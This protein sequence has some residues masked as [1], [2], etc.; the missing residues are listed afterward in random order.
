[1]LSALKRK[2][3]SL[4]KP[5]TN[6]SIQRCVV[7]H[8]HLFKNAGSTLDWALRK[9]FG[10]SFVDHR[11]DEQMKLGAS[12]L[13]SYIEQHQ[14]VQAL[15][16]HHL[17]LP[18]P[19][20]SDTPLLLLTLFRHPIERVTSV[21]KF[22][23]AQTCNSTPGVI[24]ARKLS[25]RDYILWRMKPRVGSTIR[26]FH[27]RRMLPPRELGQ[28]LISSADMSLINQT[29]ETMDMVGTVERF[30]ESM[31]LFE[32]CLKAYYPEIDLSYVPQNVGQDP[33][34]KGEQRL[35]RLRSD[36]GDETYNLLLEKNQADLEV[37]SFVQNEL[38]KRI[39]KT[40]NFQEKLKD[41]QL[42]CQAS[43]G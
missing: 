12:Y 22:E 40:A 2:L 23:R 42:R 10:S 5:I 26:N 1:M 43:K 21:Y 33:G 29:I 16:S 28:E 27:A 38:D 34:E 4:K 32:E 35:E 37:Y 20:V 9:N 3:F 7:L 19:E 17:R 39:A 36:V 15:S 8:N 11:D 30:D 41:F 14:N 6:R 24:H 18:L 13:G 25:L 31:V